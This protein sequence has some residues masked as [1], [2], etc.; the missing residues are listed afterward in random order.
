MR[1]NS[2]IA[3]EEKLQGSFLFA[4]NMKMRQILIINLYHP[5][6]MNIN[7]KIPSTTMPLMTNIIKKKKNMR[8]E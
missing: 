1:I 3:Y 8:I 6:Q 7:P 4:L 5:I 2:T